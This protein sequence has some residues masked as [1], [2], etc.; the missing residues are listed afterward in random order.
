[1]SESE[2]AEKTGIPPAEEPPAPTPEEMAKKM[3]HGLWR[4]KPNIVVRVEG[5]GA[6]VFD[7]DSDSISVVNPMASALLQWRR[8][9]ICFDEWCEALQTHYKETEPVQIQADVRKFL[10]AIAHFAESYES[11]GH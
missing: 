6:I 3:C 10:G 9:R 2:K 11:E 7:P 5:D 1:M 8:D 4:L